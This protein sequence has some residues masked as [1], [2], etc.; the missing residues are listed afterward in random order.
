MDV[1]E[2][3]FQVGVNSRLV[4]KGCLVLSKQVVEMHDADGDSFVLLDLIEDLL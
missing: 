3:V 2:Q 1:E 4:V